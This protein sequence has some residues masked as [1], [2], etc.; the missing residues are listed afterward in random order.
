MN[1]VRARLIW[2]AAPA[3]VAREGASREGRFARAGEGA[4]GLATR[5]GPGNL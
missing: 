5:A 3:T 2:G 4:V 1:E